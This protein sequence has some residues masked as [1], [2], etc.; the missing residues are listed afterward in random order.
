MFTGADQGSGAGVLL[1]GEKASYA[2]FYRIT[3]ADVD[4]GGMANSATVS[5]TPPLGAPVSDVSDNGDNTD[6]NTT[7]DQT[8]LILTPAPALALDKRLAAGSGP[9]FDT[10]GQMLT[11]EFRITNTG[12][13][14][15]TISQADL[16]A[17]QVVNQAFA[18]TILAGGVPVTSPAVSVTVPAATAPG[19]TLSKT[20]APNPVAAVGQQITYTLVA[21]NTG[22][23]SLTP[24]EIADPL[25]PTLVCLAASLPVGQALQCQGS[26]T[27]TQADVDAGTLV[28]TAT[29][30]GVTPQGTGTATTATEVT[31]MPGAAP[32]LTLV[33][34]AVPTPFGAVGS[35]LTYRM[36]V[37]NSGN[38]T[39]TNILVTDPMDPAFQCVIA[40]LQPGASDA[41][42]AV[43]ITITQAEVDAGSIRN[44]GTVTGLDPSG[45]PIT[46]SDSITTNGGPAQ[47]GI[48]ATKV[49]AASGSV[50]GSVLSYQLSLRNTGNVTLTASPPTD[51]MTR[52]DGTST[53]LDTAF[54]LI[55]GDPDSDG[56]L[57][58]G[59]I[60]I[61]LGNHILTQADIDAG[62][63]SNSV[64]AR[65]TDPTGTVVTDLSDNGDDTDGN[66]TDDPTV[67]VPVTLPQLTVTKVLSNVQGTAAGD[68]VTYRI[69]ALNSGTGTLTGL[70]ITDSLTR[71]DGT[72]VANATPV[73][74]SGGTTLAPGAA[75]V[76]TLTHALTQ[77]DIDAGGLSNA[78]IGTAT[79]MAGNTVT[80]VSDNGNPFDGNTTDDPTLL[81]ITPAP[82]LEVIK[83]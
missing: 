75:T 56:L 18:G 28:N 15:L 1:P 71:A 78:V 16:D 53:A 6:G 10:A 47:P 12:N 80:D 73:L 61:Y 58:V 38:L 65:A 70:A 41:T 27:V 59:E 43:A 76:W 45:A 74:V 66:T 33:K 22:N 40:S 72:P 30:T 81:P 82:A 68:L 11:Y 35:A 67:F 4:A 62:G 51:E 37:T 44:T 20:A 39:I 69:T 83:S 60:W 54:A 63:L 50:A 23:Q 29:A 52:L 13:A 21:T 42:C 19:L 31:G 8:V 7:D 26:Y 2:A 17:G 34:S 9:A 64:T 14:T 57:D 79:D 48:E 55:S 32:A 5:G 25:I 77:A 3:Q 36:A 46:G 24:V 49:V